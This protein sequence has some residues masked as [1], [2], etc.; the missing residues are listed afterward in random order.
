[1]L[2]VVLKNLERALARTVG[3]IVPY[4]ALYGRR[5]EPRVAVVYRGLYKL[6]RRAC[7]VLEEFTVKIAHHKLAARFDGDLEE[8]FLFA[9][10][11][12]KHAMPRNALYALRKIVILRVYGILIL[13]RL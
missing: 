2:E 5:Y 4:L 6:V 12:R 8:A 13:C 11:D 10:V 9:A 7:I 1:M 3:K